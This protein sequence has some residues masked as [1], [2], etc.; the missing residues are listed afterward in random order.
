MHVP[1][2]KRHTQHMSHQPRSEAFPPAVS[3]FQMLEMCCSDISQV[4]LGFLAQVSAVI[5]S[6]SVL[7]TVLCTCPVICLLSDWQA[8]CF[9]V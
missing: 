3:L 5:L 2:L 6:P 4:N 7:S 1:V 9:S 8:G